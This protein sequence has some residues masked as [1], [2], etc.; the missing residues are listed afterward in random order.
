MRFEYAPG[1]TPI[2]PDQAKGLE[3]VFEELM[4]RQMLIHTLGVVA[5]A[6]GMMKLSKE[7]GITR[8][9]LYKTLS[10]DGNPSFETVTKIVGAFGMRL[11]AQAA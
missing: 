11:S 4:D 5:R 8:A 2:D 10:P 1:A 7:T 6:R 9:G 3:A